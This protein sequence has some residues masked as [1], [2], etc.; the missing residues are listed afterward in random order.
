MLSVPDELTMPEMEDVELPSLLNGTES[1]M[2]NQAEVDIANLLDTDSLSGNSHDRTIDPDS[3]SP[4]L[5]ADKRNHSDE[6]LISMSE[7]VVDNSIT[8]SSK[9][10]NSPI[11][12]VPCAIYQPQFF[13][14]PPTN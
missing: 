8:H 6:E 10:S 5:V 7:T 2:L 12:A 13:G 9:F 11:S 14:C 4:T 1:F 3:G